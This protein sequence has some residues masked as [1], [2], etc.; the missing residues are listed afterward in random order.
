MEVPADAQEQSRPL[1]PEEIGRKDPPTP[2]PEDCEAFHRG[3]IPLPPHPVRR[4][5]WPLVQNSSA[6]ASSCRF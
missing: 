6:L 4:L 1:S 5:L 3:L 2:P